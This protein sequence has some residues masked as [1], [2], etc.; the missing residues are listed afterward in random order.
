MINLTKIKLNVNNVNKNNLTNLKYNT[1]SE[2]VSLY[3]SKLYSNTILKYNMTYIL[4]GNQK[5]TFTKYFVLS[6]IVNQENDTYE[7]TDSISPAVV[8]E[9]KGFIKYIVFKNE[10]LKTIFN[11]QA[12]DEEK[13]SVVASL[14]RIS[15]DQFVKIDRLAKNYF[16]K[17]FQDNN[18]FDAN[19]RKKII[20]EKIFN[21]VGK[22]LKRKQI[23]KT[24]SADSNPGYELKSTSDIQNK[25]Q[26]LS[27][28]NKNRFNNNNI[29]ILSSTKISK[30]IS[31]TALNAILDYDY[32]N[33]KNYFCNNV[34]DFDFKK[35]NNII[36]I[37]KH[38][39]SNQAI[40]ELDI[41]KY[42]ENIQ[43]VSSVSAYR[44]IN[45]EFYENN[46]KATIYKTFNNKMLIDS[47]FLFV[48]KLKN[49]K[50][51]GDKIVIMNSETK[52]LCNFNKEFYSRALRI[53][54]IKNV[55]NDKVLSNT[56][57]NSLFIK[58]IIER[59][60][61]IIEEKNK[62]NFICF[63]NIIKSRKENNRISRELFLNV[64]ENSNLKPNILIEEQ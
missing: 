36:K 52:Q 2:D 46:F 43:N 38:S 32:V 59:Y 41:K 40:T 9:K 5:K 54:G 10:D 7:I 21:I 62:Q 11:S 42:V 19:Y 27:Y 3:Y 31:Q 14:N 13:E 64:N 34:L 25:L 20:F 55:N 30:E 35:N 53:W 23:N 26:K 18:N 44:N 56:N 47:D 1:Q 12:T 4:Q 60:V 29:L 39:R 17:S 49:L 15:P 48:K 58:N 24:N 61:I 22:N 45:I 50:L 8:L 57:R 63:N 6:E 16:F 33:C 51:E 28:T 37:K